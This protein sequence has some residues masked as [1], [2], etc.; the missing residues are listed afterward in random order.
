MK[1]KSIAHALYKDCHFLYKAE[2]NEK[3]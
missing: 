3:K 2:L 1:R